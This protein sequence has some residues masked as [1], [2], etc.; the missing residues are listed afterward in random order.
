MLK[1]QLPPYALQWIGL[2]T[3]V[4]LLAL[5]LF[6]TMTKRHERKVDNVL[7][8][9]TSQS[10][11]IPFTS[12]PQELSVSSAREVWDYYQRIGFTMENLASGHVDVPRIY[13]ANIINTWAR[14]ESIAFKKSLFYRTML[15]L[16]LRINELIAAERKQLISLLAKKKKTEINLSE[17]TWLH[18]LAVD[19]KV[20]SRSYSK[21][22]SEKHLAALLRRVDIIPTSMALGQ[23][24]YESAYATSRFAMEGNALFG[25]WRWGS[26]LRPA[27]QRSE[28]GDYRIADFVTPLDSMAAFAKN[29]NTNKAY[30]EFRRL[31]SGMRKRNEPLDGY[32]LA[33]G[34]EKYSEKGKTYVETLRGMISQ[35]N[36]TM[37]DKVK[38]GNGRPVS[39]IPNWTEQD[40]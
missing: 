23:A 5:A 18:E 37:L 6:L 13:L 17:S 3:A 14:D 20:V 15:P 34:L 31:R 35:N 29:L 28:L 25:Q 24:A 7:M 26:G 36:L 11:H 12:L 22:L 2:S 39:L 40:K 16:I 38:L 21:A 33:A 19:Y 9:L 10:K 30:L 1:K 27:N 4:L 8:P 32:A